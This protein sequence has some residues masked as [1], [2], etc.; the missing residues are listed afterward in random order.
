MMKEK[1]P[2]QYWEFAEIFSKKAS[3]QLPLHKDKVN[4]DIILKNEKNLTLSSL[5]SMSLKQL[6]LVKTYLKDH[7]KKGF[8]VLSDA[9]YASSVLFAKKPE[10]GWRFCVN[11]WKLNAITKKDKYPLPLIEETLARLV[12]V[13]V[14]TKLNVRQAFYRIRMKESVED[15]T[16]FQTRYRFYKY[17]VLPFNLCNSPASF[18]RY[19]NDI[20]FNYLNDFCTV[21]VNNILIYSDNLLKHDTQVKKVLQRLKE[22]ELQADIKKS[23]FSVQS[24]KFLSFIISTEGIAM[25]SEKVTVVKNWSISKSVKE[26]QFF[27]SFCNF[28][29]NSL[30]KWDQVIRSLTKLTAKRAWHTLEELEIQAFEK[31]KELVLSDAVW[32][33]YSSYA[34]IRMKTDASDE[35]VAR[36]LTQ[37]QKDEKWKS[38]AYFSKTMSPEEM[39]Y[40]IHD[41]EM[42]TV[43]RAL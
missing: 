7:L 18:Q 28:Y 32:V 25:N 17:K 24:I 5:Y 38:A 13:K 21:Y 20:L 43:V 31:V 23:E 6:K 12:R 26:I 34:E 3:D 35:V 36:V 11:Y 4:H 2:Q 16:T 22:A 30:K 33:H 29:C 39:R 9:S 42:L 10:G 19:I 27:L 1:L 37:L 15:L 41:K 14:F 40:E 8:I